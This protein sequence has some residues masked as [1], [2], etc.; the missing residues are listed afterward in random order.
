MGHH[1]VVQSDPALGDQPL[2]VAPAGDARRG[3]GIW[4][5]ARRGL[6]RPWRRSCAAAAI[7]AAKMRASPGSIRN[8][9]CH[10][11]PR[12]KRWRGSSMP[13][14]TPSGASAL[15]TAPRP[16]VAHRLMVRGVHLHLRGA[17]DAVQQRARH[18]RDRVA[19][20]VARVGLL[21]RPAR[22]GTLVGDVL[23]QRAAQR[24]GQQLLRRRRCPAPA[25]C[26]PA[27]RAPGPARWRCGF[28]SA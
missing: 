4:R 21:V 12:Q 28:P 14:I 19:G 22:S 1:R 5:S 7:R 9:G 11:T 10:C 20:L 13:S 24:D 17:D 25:C 27:R 6:A 15:T 26:A 18:D 2:G 16:G 23:D 3:P 8:S